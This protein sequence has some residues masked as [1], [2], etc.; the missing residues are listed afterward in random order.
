MGYVLIRLYS[1]ENTTRLVF[2]TIERA[3][4]APQRRSASTV[5]QQGQTALETGEDAFKSLSYL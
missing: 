1:H 4:D 5:A 2:V 3:R